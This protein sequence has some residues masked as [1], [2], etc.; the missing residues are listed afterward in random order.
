MKWRAEIAAVLRRIFADHPSASLVGKVRRVRWLMHDVAILRDR[1]D[2]AAR[3]QSELSSA[4]PKSCGDGHGQRDGQ[5]SA[6]VALRTA[7]QA[8][9]TSVCP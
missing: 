9:D 7:R 2:G 5:T 1:H 3:G 6:F 4:R 8:G